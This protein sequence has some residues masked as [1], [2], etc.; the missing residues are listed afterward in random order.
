MPK[1]TRGGETYMNILIW[2]LLGLVSGW[3]ASV[4]MSTNS[5]QGMVG[6]II[7]GIVGAVVGGLAF[8]LFG[9]AGVTGF[10]LSSIL[11]ATVGAMILIWGGRRLAVVR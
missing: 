4:M 8:N 7:M 11:V 10:N 2:L 9:E 6:D 5:R 3:L 1:G